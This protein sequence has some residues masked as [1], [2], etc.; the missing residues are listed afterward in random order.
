MII[1]LLCNIANSSSGT[2]SF[3]LP[4]SYLIESARL[5]AV[6]SWIN[7]T[8]FTDNNAQPLYA[9]FSGIENFKS[10]VLCDDEVKKNTICLGICGDDNGETHSYNCMIVDRPSTISTAITI[11][12]YEQVDNNNTLSLL[13][14][15]S[16][17]DGNDKG[18]NVV[19]EL[20]LIDG[21]IGTAND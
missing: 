12:F 17:L 2:F 19:I 6:N 20:D 4:E 16:I 5:I 7:K 9:E 8:G 10:F 21:N 18:L 14:H 15:N 3:T 13:A 11:K 1:N